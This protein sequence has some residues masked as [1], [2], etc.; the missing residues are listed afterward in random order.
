MQ[1]GISVSAVLAWDG[2]CHGGT[3]RHLG[4]PLRD[5]NIQIALV[6]LHLSMWITWKTWCPLQYRCNLSSAHATSISIATYSRTKV[7]ENRA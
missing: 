1:R 3:G 7:G 4:R 2:W 6:M 5:E